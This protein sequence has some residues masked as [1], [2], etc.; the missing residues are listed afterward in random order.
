MFRTIKI[1]ADTML[2]HSAAA[3]A[4]CRIP[5][6]RGRKAPIK[7]AR[8][9]LAFAILSS[10]DAS[11]VRQ[12]R[13]DAAAELVSLSVDFAVRLPGAV[14]E[15]GDDEVIVGSSVRT[16]GL[17]CDTKATFR[18]TDKGGLSVFALDKRTNRVET[19]TFTENSDGVR[20]AHINIDEQRA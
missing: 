5:S 6:Y 18:S 11:V 3:R 9:S 16:C 17:L 8:A 2:A 1:P 14:M 13:L 10:R 12:D 20:F 4:F 7:A 19:W 15:R